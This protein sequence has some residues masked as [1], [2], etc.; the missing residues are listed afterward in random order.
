M[1]VKIFKNFQKIFTF[2]YIILLFVFIP[3]NLF[4]LILK[5]IL[6]TSNIKNIFYFL[7]F[8]IINDN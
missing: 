1:R 8:F 6:I 5:L 4:N 2:Y 3:T 7:I